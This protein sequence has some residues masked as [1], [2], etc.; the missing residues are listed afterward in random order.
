MLFT[1]LGKDLRRAWRNPWPYI[2]NLALPICITALIGLAM[3]GCS[4]TK[5]VAAIKVAVVDEDDSIFT[6][7]LRGAMNQGEAKK[8]L[9]LRFLARDEA[10]GQINANEISAVLVIPPNFSSDYLSGKNPAALE[11]IKNPAQSFYP[12]IFEELLSAGLAVLNAIAR[13]VGPDLSEWQKVF[14]SNQSPPDMKTVAVLVERIGDRFQ[15][16]KDYLFPPLVTYGKETKEKARTGQEASNIFAYVLP[17][18][19]A[20]FLLFLADHGVRDLYREIHAHTFDRFRTLHIR[21]MPLIGSKIVLAMAILLISS[22]ILFIGGALV[23]RLNWARPLPLIVLIVAYSLCAAGL[24]AL[25]AALTRTERRAD[26][27]NSAI[28]LAMAF[29]GGSFFPA[30]QLP[31][32]FANYISPVLPNYWFIEA[33]RGLESAAGDQWIIAA[34]KLALMGIVM[35]FA[36]AWL[37]ERTL[38]KGARG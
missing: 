6:S 30:R 28:I 37:F 31:P 34:S 21:L 32:V 16:V 29:I 13:N 26:V 20:M 7:L 33:A 9:D 35:I 38:G 11:L 19:A 10:M 12:A 5:S 17:G 23:F 22:G 3:G 8:Y 4:K 18:L 24:M 15:A 25:I 14:E 27:L 36:A 2:M 1:L